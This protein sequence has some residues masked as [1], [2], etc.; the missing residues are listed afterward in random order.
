MN[1][2]KIKKAIIPAA[3]LGTR[4]LP[5]TKAMPKEMLPILD[6]PTIQFIVEEA[7]NSGIE[8]I[9]IVV[10]QSKNSIIDHFDYSFELEERLKFKNKW[11]DYEM[12]RKIGDMANI[13]YIRQKE[14]MGLGHAILSSKF[15]VNNEP[16]A[17]L[18]GDDVIIQKNK[19]DKPALKQCM[20]L[21]YEKGVSIVGVQEVPHKDVVKYGIVEPDSE[22]DKTTNSVKLKNMIEKPS[23]DKSPSNLAILGRYILCPTIFKELENSTFNS[24]Q[25][26]EITSAL[27]ELA[28][29]EGVYAKK[30]TGKR[31]DIG[32]KLG[33]LQATIDVSLSHPEIRNELL[34]YLDEVIIREKKA[35]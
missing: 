19:D 18:L 24:Q 20:D 10:S 27:L 17:V 3:G 12:I 5:A 11:S 14:P 2:L 29:K 26:I 25:E 30:F 8:E 13:H 28:K 9:L 33:F 15:F 34:K 32:S 4:F 35:K 31:Y 6:K 16:F 21:F 22:F 1:Q 7:I 23:L